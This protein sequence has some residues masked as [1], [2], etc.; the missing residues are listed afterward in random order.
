MPLHFRTGIFALLVTVVLMAPGMPLRAQP[1]PG[2]L[3]TGWSVTGGNATLVQNGT[4]LNINQTTPQA[5]VNF[6]TFNVGSGALL[7]IRQ[8]NS[9]SALLARTTGGELSQIYGQI[10]ANG[11]LWLINPAGIMVGAG[12]RIDVGSFIASTLHV[13]D[14]DFLA[15]RL[16]FQAGGTPGELRNAGTINAAGGGRI[17]LV[18]SSVVNTGVAN[19]P[20]GEVLLAAGQTVQLLDTGTPGVSVTIT[21]ADG[22]VKN[23][24]RIAAEAGRIGL[25]AGLVSNSGTIDASSV[26]RDGGRIFLRASNELKTTAESAISASG[27]RGGNV[28]LYADGAASINGRVSATG[29]AGPGGYVDTSGRR[30]LEVFNAPVVGRGGEWFIDPFNIEIVAADAGQNSSF[31]DGLGGIAIAATGTGSQVSAGVIVAQL[32]AGVNVT[33]STSDL[34]TEPGDITVSAAINKTGQ[35]DSALTLNAANNIVINAPIT[36]TASKLD[37]N[38]NSG[39]Q[40]PAAIHVNV[41]SSL[42][43]GALTRTHG[44][45]ANV[46]PPLQLNTCI[47]APTTPGCAAILPSLSS[48]VASP[49]TAGCSV[50][51]PTLSACVASPTAQGCSVVLPTLSSCV[52]SPTT[53]GCSV[54]LP[55]LSACVASPTAQGCSVVLPTLSLCGA[56]PTTAGCSVVLPSAITCLVTSS[57][58]PGCSTVLGTLPTV[59]AAVESTVAM[60]AASSAIPTAASDRVTPASASRDAPTS[61]DSGTQPKADA[62]VKKLYCN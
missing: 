26:V 57:A 52:A 51:L 33:I 16:N 43:G 60:S 8:P 29:S 47:A 27:N 20:G 19:A 48:C 4:T 49:T 9:A 11:A 1:A 34:G 30:S 41:S 32:N 36:S 61:A 56:S 38:L 17:Y 55:T 15:G 53:A 21:G 18:A 23:L 13:K 25:A 31:G 3:P 14:S 46:P 59:G 50:V 37:L 42:N 2:A 5:L 39:Q 22:A 12:A 35:L 62:P 6:S 44:T 40:D 45:G 24:G 54:V 58:L 7:E 28:V 10:K